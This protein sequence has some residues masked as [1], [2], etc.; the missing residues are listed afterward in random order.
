MFV[1]SSYVKRSRADFDDCYILKV[2]V[3]I[4]AILFFEVKVQHMDSADFYYVMKYFGPSP[5]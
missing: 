3:F 5:P 4:C 1:V 2:G